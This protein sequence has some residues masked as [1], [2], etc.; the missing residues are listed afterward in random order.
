MAQQKKN[1]RFH[2]DLTLGAALVILLTL[3][4]CTSMMGALHGAKKPAAT[5][6]GLGPRN[7][8]HGLYTA[9]LQPSESLRPRKLQTIQ[10]ALADAE[11]HAVD[12]AVITIDGGMPQ[13]GHGLPTRPRVTKSAAGGV[14]V[15][16]GVRFN[17]GGWWEFRL[18][19][20]GKAGA[21][22]VTFNLAL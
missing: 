13:H 3:S 20:D 9:T 14:Y 10:V 19:I 17:M 15:I 5:E 21:D 22:Q 11:G 7:S 1:S 2:A 4:A 6:F 8:A 16:E 18:A 12:G